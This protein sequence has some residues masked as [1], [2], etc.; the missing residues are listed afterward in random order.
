MRLERGF[1][2][3]RDMS[4]ALPNATDP[5]RDA[6]NLRASQIVLIEDAQGVGTGV[7]VGP[8]G[9][10]LTNKHV[11]P[12][13]GPYRV[14][15][16]DGKDVRGV[17]VHQSP[18]HD[19]AIVKIALNSPSFLD[20]NT[21][22]ADDYVV[23]EE[24]FALGHPRGCRFSM[25]RGIVSNPHREFEKEY[26]VQ[27]DVSIN[28]GNSGGPLVDRMGRLIGIVTMILS[29]SQGLGFAVPGHIAGDYVRHVRRLLRS[30]IVRI[31]TELLTQ[32]DERTNTEEVVKRA[33]NALVIAGRGAIEEEKAEEGW[34]KFKYKGAQVT[35]SLKEGLFTTRCQILALGPGERQNAPFLLKLLELSGGP[36]VGGAIVNVVE[37]ALF[38][39]VSRRAAGLDLEEATWAID[40]VANQ[41]VEAPRKLTSL[42][43]S[44]PP[45]QSAPAAPTALGPPQV[46]AAAP[47]YG[48]SSYGQPPHAPP[49]GPYGQPAQG[50]YGQPPQTG[51]YGQPP[52][53][54]PPFAAPP[55]GMP[56]YGAPPQAPYAAPP[57][58]QTPAAGTDPGYPILQIPPP[59]GYHK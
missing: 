50:P 15:L 31:P 19:L 1:S 47:L 32:A 51:P 49:A 56:P 7:L 17:G 6:L 54:A 23:G 41:G 30:N 38:V 5:S 37:N 22:I 24:V 3:V 55:H 29:N 34:I 53:A 48:G 9:F 26:Y 21:D 16:A 13:L 58:P 44:A 8:D 39:S 4:S 18:H 57:A 33:V 45:V 14:I 35:V 12:S 10:V 40:L 46:A 25:A 42:L 20:V 43:F 2:Y 52:Q 59:G 36:E 11:A 27:T 28:P